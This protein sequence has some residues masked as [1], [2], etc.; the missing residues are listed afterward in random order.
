M[1]GAIY[2]GLTGLQAYSQGLQNV[3]NNVSNLNS[4]GFK[5]SNVSFSNLQST[6]DYG[7]VSLHDGAGDSG[8]GVNL[9]RPSLDMSAGELRQTDRDLDLAIDGTGL[10]VLMKDGEVRY[11]RTGSFVVDD[12]GYV[13]LSGTEWRLGML[14]A[15]GRPTP[16]SI[17]PSRTNAPVKTE[18]IVFAD[19][20]S[21][22]AT[23][24]SINDVSVYDASGEKHVWQLAFARTENTSDWSITVT[25]E[26]G[27]TIGEQTLRFANGSPTDET[28][29]LV[30]EDAGHGLSVEL[31]FSS[32]VTSFSSGTLST[33][34]TSS[35]DGHA[36]G[37]IT[38]ISVNPEG[39]LEIGYSNDEKLQL[40]PVAIAAFRD[41]QALVQESSGLFATTGKPTVEYLAS[42]DPRVGLVKSRRLEASNVDLS[43]EF[44]EL[45]LIQ[46]G[47]Q[48]S[49]QIVSIANDMIQ[50]LFAIRGQG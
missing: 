33:L 31:D 17:D 5:T 4:I 35:V 39:E 10:L 32:N 9:N 15:A 38:T 45:I 6:R 48:A 7:G 1:F 47:Y 22:T 49:S 36:V 24:Y 13:T 21:S 44:G 2:V 12:E 16:L 28:A 34:R 3:S 25:D 50:Q 23:T 29:R 40:A 11:T 37:T 19:N 27:T 41:T 46:R 8:G 30:F 26:S 18:T 42:S 20:L 43:R 14:D